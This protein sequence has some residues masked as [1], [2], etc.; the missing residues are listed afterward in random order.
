M[1]NRT[2]TQFLEGLMVDGQAAVED[3]P[4]PLADEPALQLLSQWHESAGGELACAAPAFSGPAAGWAAGVF[5][6]VCQS[7]VCRDI[8][9]KEMVSALEQRCPG[10]R[11]PSVDW[12][13]DLV[14][15]RLPEVFRM[16]RH[17]SAADPLVRELLALAAAW[18]LSSVGIGELGK[19]GLESFVG[20]AGLRQLYGDRI[21]ATRDVSRLGDRRV[22]ATLRASLGAHPELC[23]E[24]ANK[25]FAA[26]HR[27]AREA[28]G[29]G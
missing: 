28:K 29:P 6:S 25:L 18:P 1:A 21:L 17:L 14:F 26:G 22:D 16:A 19:L 7:V 20:H 4:A 11:S 10:H 15:R 24:I 5:Y 8:G 9:E 2:L 27:D 3:G 13:V 23:S 12:S